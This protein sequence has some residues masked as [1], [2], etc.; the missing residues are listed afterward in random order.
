VPHLPHLFTD[1]DQSVP[2]VIENLVIP[3]AERWQRITLIAGDNMVPDT[4]LAAMEPLDFPILQDVEISGAS[5]AGPSLPKY[6]LR[7]SAP[8]LRRCRF[9]D[10]PFVPSLPSNLAV[11][12]C[13]F[14]EFG[15]MQFDLEP[16]LELL[17]HVAHSLEHLRFGPPP[18]SNLQHI[19]D[20]SRKSQILTDHAFL[21]DHGTYSRLTS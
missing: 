6:A 4:L 15:L 3:G 2:G 19:Q 18:A 21:C 14:A 5:L 8:L 16:W 17:P 20:S 11:L 13:V 7:H 1:P 12:D 9:R 10:V